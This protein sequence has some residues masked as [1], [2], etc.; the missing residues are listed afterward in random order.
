MATHLVGSWIWAKL[1]S[2][3]HLIS[4]RGEE[5]LDITTVAQITAVQKGLCNSVHLT[6]RQQQM[7]MAS[8]QC[9]TGS[10]FALSMKSDK[11]EPHLL[12]HEYGS[13]SF[14]IESQSSAAS[15]GKEL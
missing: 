15:P 13:L 5:S 11:E 10:I 14:A 4:C 7:G 6:G 9:C 3:M 12:A 1:M 2:V 8:A